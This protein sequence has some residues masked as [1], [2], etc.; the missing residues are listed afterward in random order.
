[1]SGARRNVS[2]AVRARPSAIFSITAWFINARRAGVAGAC[3][4][5]RSL[6]ARRNAQHTICHSA[7]RN[8]ELRLSLSVVQPHDGYQ[9]QTRGSARARH[10]TEFPR[11]HGDVTYNSIALLCVETT[12]I[13][14]EDGCR[15]P[16]RA[17]AK[18]VIYSMLEGA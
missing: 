12:R 5:L 17:D 3:G 2:R 16:G 15:P 7:R 10:F 4:A 8:Y 13:A 1:M 14:R 18:E 6:A 9:R 11:R